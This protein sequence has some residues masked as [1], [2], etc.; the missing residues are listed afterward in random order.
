LRFLKGDFSRVDPER[1][2]FRS[3]VKSTLHNL[4]MDFHR[5]R[6]HQPQPLPAEVEEFAD[7]SQHDFDLDRP[8]LDCWRDEILSRASERL[9][10]HQ[11]R[12]GQPFHAVLRLR[13]DNPSMRSQEMSERLSSALGKP[14]TAGWV[15]QNLR[16]ARDR[17]VE[18]IEAEVAHSLGNPTVEERDEE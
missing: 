4:L 9:A 14:V 12:T 16:R 10:V 8:F 13:A 5:R 17:F 7:P 11:E 6:K 18:F 2:R 1:G 15:R 3:Y